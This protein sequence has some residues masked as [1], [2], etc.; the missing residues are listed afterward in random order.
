MRMADLHVISA[1]GGKRAELAGLIDS[2]EG[3]IAQCRADLVR[4]DSVLRLYQPKRDRTEIRPK[5]SVHRNRCFGSGE[6]A[7]L[8]LDAFRNAVGP[9]PVSDIVERVITAKGFDTGDRVLQAAISELVK[10]TLAPM[11]RRRTIEKIGQGRPCG[12]C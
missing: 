7:R 9:L 10:A 5:R 6:L 11:R 12:G 8:C 3:Q 1:L 4:L 2:L